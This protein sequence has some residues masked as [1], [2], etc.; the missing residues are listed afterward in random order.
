MKL[1]PVISALLGAIIGFAAA[2]FGSAAVLVAAFGDREGGNGM[3]GFFGFGPVG[4]IAGTLMGAGLALTFGPAANEWGK[5]LIVSGGVV[6]GIGVV[7]LL[8]ASTPDRGPNYSEV[9]EFELE[10]TR[11]RRWNT[12]RFQVPTP[13]GAPGVE[14]RMTPLSLSSSKRNAAE[15]CVL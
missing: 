2:G 1:L 12:L 13:C 14:S 6:L 5:R 4:A 10:Y 9:I 11:P 15:M 3:A 7:V 8:V